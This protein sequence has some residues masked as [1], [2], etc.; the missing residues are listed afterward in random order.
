MNRPDRGGLDDVVF[1]IA[2]ALWPRDERSV[3]E[4]ELRPTFEARRARGGGIGDLLREG[5]DIAWAGAEAR[6]AGRATSASRPPRE[7]S[8]RRIAS[9]A[10]HAARGLRRSPG[11]ALATGCILGVGVT[12]ATSVFAVADAVLMRPLPYP[13]SDDLLRIGVEREARPGLSTMSGPNFRDLEAAAA[14][15]ASVTA[16]S[17]STMGVAADGE[18]SE[19]I[20]GGWVSG[21]FFRTLGVVPAS[22]RAFGPDDDRKGAPLTAVLSA[23]LAD[24]LFGETSPVGRSIEIDARPATVVGVMPATFHPPEGAGLGDTELWAPLAHAPLPTGDRGLAFLDAVGRISAGETETTVSA[25]LHSIGEG[26]VEVH[27]LPPR[28]FG[29]LAARPLRDE[30]V[31]GAGT[32]LRL[33]LAAVL[34][35][36]AIAA[37]NTANLVLLRGLDRTGALR[38]RLALGASRARIVAESVTESTL[39]ATV[40]GILGV[41][42]AALAVR[43]LV[44]WDPIDLPRLAEASVDL[45]VSVLCLVLAATVGAGSGLIPAWVAA[46]E[47]GLGHR[48]SKGSG[49]GRGAK[50]L[51]DGAVVVQVGLGLALAGGA[52]LVGRSLISARGLPVGMNVDDLYVATLRIDGIGGEGFDPSTLDRLLASARATPGVVTAGLGSGS[53]YVPGG[54]VGYLE[55]EGV[56]TSDEDRMRGRVEFHRVSGATLELLGIPLARG[57]DLTPADRMGS[58]PV[59]VI[60]EAAVRAWWGGEDALGRQAILGGDGS[61]TPRRVVGIAADPRYR[62]PGETPEQHAWVPWSQMPLAPVDLRV[63]TEAGMEPARLIAAAVEG[64]PGVSVRGVR[65]VQRELAKRFVEPTFYT[66]L[67]GAFAGSALLFAGAGLYATLSHTVQRRHGEFGIRMALGAD[68]ERLVWGVVVRGAAVTGVGLLLGGALASAGA[69]M[70]ASFLFGIQPGDPL[71]WGVAAA[72]LLLTGAVA[73][74]VPA[75]RAGTTDPANSLRSD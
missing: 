10:S 2:L 68:R 42:L 16:F 57:R 40:G 14:T 20:R 37:L 21:D 9:V 55:P 58:E 30:T 45:R 22:G 47:A 71:A 33:L 75:W 43:A 34:L 53:P 39:V 69:R 51:R 24:R 8:A 52:V 54:M 49:T 46:R 41:G 13:E 35:L 36:L 72:L 67:F 17:P 74:G 32:T 64:V 73:S 62:G 50:L 4:E 19:L 65:S 29:G 15:L 25:E 12:A 61:F 48:R 63:R 44:A 23:Q 70:T 38:V 66:V 6:L 31:E 28:A 11:W 26:L 7:G 27:A 56:E 60:N 3:V 59:I 18:P 1:Q 5:L